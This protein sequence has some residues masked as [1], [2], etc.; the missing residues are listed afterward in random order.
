VFSGYVHEVFI[1]GDGTF[2]HPSAKARLP[3]RDPSVPRPEE[4]EQAILHQIQD[5]NILLS[6]ADGMTVM[7]SGSIHDVEGDIEI[8]TEEVVI[9]PDHSNEVQILDYSEQ[10][11]TQH[12]Q[13]IETQ[14]HHHGMVLL[15]LDNSGILHHHRHQLTSLILTHIPISNS[16]EIQH[17]T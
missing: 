14:G 6:Q 2:S 4:S 8:D 1:P 16:L 5:N 7:I 13:H 3:I 12:H 11:S 9:G 10:H 17:L 15:Q